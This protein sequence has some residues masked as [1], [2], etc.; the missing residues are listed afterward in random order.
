V[1]EVGEPRREPIR[2]TASPGGILDAAAEITRERGYEGTSVSLG[3]LRR[4]R[5]TSSI[6]G[7]RQRSGERH[8]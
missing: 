4:G 1:K 2:V 7:G 6:D 3:S 8:T 5:P